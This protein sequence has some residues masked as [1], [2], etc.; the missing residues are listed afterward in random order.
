MTS[1]ENSEDQEDGTKTT[2]TASEADSDTKAALER[3]QGPAVALIKKE[4]GGPK[5]LKRGTSKVLLS[6]RKESRVLSRGSTLELPDLKKA[7][8]KVS[9]R[10]SEMTATPA[11][12]TQSKHSKSK[13]SQV[14]PNE[15]Q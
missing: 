13:K 4:R 14:T 2:K 8:S 15:E 3:M 10:K 6:Q 7:V 5:L 11:D 1:F 9:K 12:K